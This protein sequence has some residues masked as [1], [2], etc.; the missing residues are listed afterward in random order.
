MYCSSDG[1]NEC[2]LAEQYSSCTFQS[3]SSKINFT[4]NQKDGSNKAI[5]VQV[6][7]G[8]NE[9]HPLCE[10]RTRLNFYDPTLICRRTTANPVGEKKSCSWS[11]PDVS[12]MTFWAWL[13]LIRSIQILL[14]VWLKFVKCM[15]QGTTRTLQMKL[16]Q[17]IKAIA[18]TNIEV[19]ENNK[20]RTLTTTKNRLVAQTRQWYKIQNT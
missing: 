7:H 14:G 16:T 13:I 6:L 15:Y 3:G 10:L 17:T 9:P 20:T 11:R 18:H 12:Q 5:I 4:N 19:R 2:K 8:L 1:K